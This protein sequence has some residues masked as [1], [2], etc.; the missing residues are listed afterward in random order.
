[1]V[2]GALSFDHATGNPRTFA[3]KDGT[4]GASFEIVASDFSFVGSKGDTPTDGQKTPTRATNAQHTGDQ[5]P[6]VVDAD[7]IP[8]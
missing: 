6:S 8:F 4:T 7:D 1:L 5:P 3:R 2:E